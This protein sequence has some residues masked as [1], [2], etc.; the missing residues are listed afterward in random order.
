[1][2]QRDEFQAKLYEL[3]KT[4]RNLQ[5]DKRYLEEHCNKLNQKVHELQ[6]N[7]ANK[8]SKDQINNNRKPFISTVR[9]GSFFSVLKDADSDSGPTQSCWRCCPSTSRGKLA[10]LEAEREKNHAKDMMD[11]AELYK[12]QV[13]HFDTDCYQSRLLI[14]SSSVSSS[15][16]VVTV[17]LAA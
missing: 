1:M 10:R 17:K 6:H 11:L 12:K 13:M 14:K 4:I 3:S 16:I 7:D 15:W 5:V 2:R 8:K 9:S